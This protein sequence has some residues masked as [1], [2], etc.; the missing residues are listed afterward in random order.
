MY[1]VCMTGGNNPW[2]NCVRG[3]LRAKGKPDYD[4]ADHMYCWERLCGYLLPDVLNRFVT[5]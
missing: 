3:C 1:L 2:A 4:Q 5:P